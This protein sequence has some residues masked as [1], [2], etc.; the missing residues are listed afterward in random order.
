MIAP[1]AT[2][3]KVTETGDYIFRV[4]FIDPFQGTVMAKFAQEDLKAKK[5]A[6]ISS[7][8]NAYSVGLAKFFH[9]T[10][11]NGGGTVAVE[12][13][14]S[15]GDKDFR[16]QLTAVKAAG[17]EAVFVPGY[18]T[19]SALIVRQARDLGITVP[20][21]GGDGWESD[22]LLEIGGNALNGC[23]YSTH[24]SPENNDPNVAKFVQKF[25]ARWNN[26]TPDAFASLGYDAAYV[27]VDAIKR[28][29]TTEGP[30]L[31]DALA[32]TKNFAGASGVTTIDQNR[33][34][35]KGATIIAIKDG[36]LAFHRTVAP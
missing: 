3:P 27:L 25:K 8:S 10:F 2:N 30:Q 19:E 21:I 31:R 24:F 20:F 11:T 36:K 5:V 18:Y 1:A 32:A 13:K 29:G 15:E 28:A 9:E 23:F 26:E 34:A 33:N 35:T 6:I 17:V 12:Q 14:Y 4:C 7:V 22:K 16:A